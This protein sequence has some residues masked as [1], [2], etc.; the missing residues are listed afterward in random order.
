MP[1][2]PNERSARREQNKTEIKISFRDGT[3]A[4]KEK[5]EQ[6]AERE[7]AEI[8]YAELENAQIHKSDESRN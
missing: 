6:L 4:I 7:L 8:I 5:V 2:W 1:K 3:N